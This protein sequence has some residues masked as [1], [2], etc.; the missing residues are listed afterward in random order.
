MKIYENH[1]VSP[2][3]NATILANHRFPRKNVYDIPISG[4]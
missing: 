4:K 2:V 1:V 3:E